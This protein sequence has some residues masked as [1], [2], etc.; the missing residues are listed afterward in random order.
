MSGMA[1]PMRHAT[2]PGGH[3]FQGQMATPGRMDQG[4]G[5]N[6]GG[7]NAG[8]TGIQNQVYICLFDEMVV[9]CSGLVVMCGALAHFFLVSVVGII[10]MGSG[11]GPHVQNPKTST[12]SLPRASPLDQYD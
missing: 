1:T 11:D 6:T 9:V 10:F 3:G 7:I 2:T 4:F 5:G 8:L 12:R